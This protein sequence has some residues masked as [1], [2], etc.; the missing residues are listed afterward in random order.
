MTAVALVAIA[1]MARRWRDLIIMFKVLFVFESV[2][3][4]RQ[5][6]RFTEGVRRLHTNKSRVS[7]VPSVWSSLSSAA[8]GAW[9]MTGV[10]RGK[11]NCRR[12]PGSPRGDGTEADA[13]ADADGDRSTYDQSY[14][15][16]YRDPTRGGDD[17]DK[18]AAAAPVRLTDVFMPTATRRP[19]EA[20]DA[21]RL[22]KAPPRAGG[23]RAAD[24][25]EY[26]RESLAS[27]MSPAAEGR[28]NDVGDDVTVE[29][30]VLVPE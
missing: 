16:R 19:A 28:L 25:G 13:P 20:L 12:Y 9:R 10:E 30:E 6:R 8:P 11:W 7:L 24:E 3:V 18:A 5:A 27:P 17:A 23:D 29:P 14:R 4:Y 1:T 21:Y 22:R 15:D 2:I 26:A